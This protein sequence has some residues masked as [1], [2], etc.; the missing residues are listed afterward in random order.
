MSTAATTTLL[1][2]ALL[3]PAGP[4]DAQDDWNLELAPY[5][6]TVGTDADVT[7]D[8]QTVRVKRDFGSVDLG[9]SVL[10]AGRIDRFVIWSQ[11]DFLAL[12]TDELE[13]VPGRGRLQTDLSLATLGFGHQFGQGGGTTFDVL[14]GAR[15]LH[16]DSKLL[17]NG[18]GRFTQDE[19][20]TDAVVIVRPSWSLSERWLFNPTVSLGGGDSKLTWELQPQFQYRL[21]ENIAVR[22]GYRYVYY[23]LDSDDRV[24]N[25][26][27]AIDGMIFGIGGLFRL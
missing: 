22:F 8:S 12:D 5:L 24:S 11:L 23:R 9:G 2:L 18:V 27:G 7:L 13:R 6:W 4:L 3:L 15:H 21:T 16:I 1:V 19:D 17:L 26:D 14:L 10:G 25:W 20:F